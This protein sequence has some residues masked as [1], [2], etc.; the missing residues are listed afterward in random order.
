VFRRRVVPTSASDDVDSGS[1]IVASSGIR[2]L[3][4]MPFI[5]AYLNAAM[6][7]GGMDL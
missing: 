3:E 6:L 1:L 7:L 4:G 5:D 2:L